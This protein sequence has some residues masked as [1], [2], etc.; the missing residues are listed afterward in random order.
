[1]IF[2]QFHVRNYIH[3]RTHLSKHTQKNRHLNMLPFLCE[4]TTKFALA[5]CDLP[6]LISSAAML[7]KIKEMI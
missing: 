6:D 1:M 2:M 4:A 3:N 7:S 5:Y